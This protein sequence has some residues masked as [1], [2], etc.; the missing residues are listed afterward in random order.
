MSPRRAISSSNFEESVIHVSAVRRLRGEGEGGGSRMR[1][2][3]VEARTRRTRRRRGAAG[4][5]RKRSDGQRTVVEQRRCYFRM[6][7][8]EGRLSLSQ[9]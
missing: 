1:G 2:E 9:R 3:K 8:V 6:N 7:I 4:R 5:R